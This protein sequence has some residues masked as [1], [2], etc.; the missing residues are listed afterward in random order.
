VTIAGLSGYTMYFWQVRAVNAAGATC[1]DAGGGDPSFWRFT[2]GMPPPAAFSKSGPANYAQSLPTLLSLT[3]QATAGANAYEYCIDTWDNGL[4]DGA[5]SWVGTATTTTLWL[6]PF[7][8]YYWQVRATNGGGATDADGGTFWRFTTGA[9][10]PGAF[11]KTSPMS[12]ARAGHAS[13]TLAWQ[14]S[15][16][17]TGYEYCYDRSNNAACDATWSSAGSSTSA[18]LSGLAAGTKYYWQVRATGSGTTEANDGIWWSF[19]TAATQLGDFSGDGKSDVLWHHSAGGEVWLWPMDGASRTAESYVRA[20]ADTTWEIRGLGDH[21]GDGQSDILWR[22]RTTGVIY[23]WEMNGSSSQRELYLG[24]VDPS[25]DIVGTGDYNGDFASDILWRHTSTGEVWIWLMNAGV[26]PV[27][28]YVDT[29]DPAYVVQASGDLNADGKADI[30]WRHATSG[31]VWVWLMN[32]TTRGTPTWAGVVADLDYRIVGVADHTG[33][34]KADIL[35]HHATRGEVWLWPMDG[36]AP[37]L[38]QDFV[39]IV[40]DTSYRI[41]GHG[42]YDGDGKADILW[43]HATLGEVWIWL[44]DGATRLSQT[45]VSTVTDVGYAPVK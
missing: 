5:W 19:T 7:T 8:T 28:T 32:G 39:G 27:R 11:G 10:P 14:P 45:Y 35:W 38:S 36:A 33:D 40:A 2:T 34:G 6:N 4:C 29:V 31:D 22:N 24:T 30:V 1:A 9:A 12:Y 17:A 16:G 42:D 13:L 37:P 20:V 41:A 18:T 43:H 3:W 25:Y 15:V 44:M 21:N 23:L 26:L